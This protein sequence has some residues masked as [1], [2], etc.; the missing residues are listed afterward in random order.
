MKTYLDIAFQGQ[1]SRFVM[2]VIDRKLLHGF[3]KRLALDPDG[4]ACTTAHLTRDGRHVLSSGSTADLYVNE[5]GDSVSRPELTPVDS[6]GHPLE[7]FSPT[8]GRSQEVEGPIAPGEILDH[9]AVKVFSL[10]PEEI[11]A[12]LQSA[13]A[14]GEIFKVPF[15]PRKTTRQI[16]AFLLANERGLYLVQAEPCGFEFVGL[17]EMTSEVGTA[18]DG[19]DEYGFEFEPHRGW[20]R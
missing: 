7:T 6:D 9:V 8:T 2:S 4:N 16:P 3:T 17:D 12:A 18:D 5:K 19:D 14:H 13:L 11:S 10:D 15:R 20:N 1:Q